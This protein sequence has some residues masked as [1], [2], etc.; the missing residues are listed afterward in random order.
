MC[1]NAA[2]VSYQYYLRGEHHWS[3]YYLMVWTL[4]MSVIWVS[5]LRPHARSIL[6]P[7][8][9]C[10]QAWRGGIPLNGQSQPGQAY[11]TLRHAPSSIHIGNSLRIWGRY[12]GSLVLEHLIQRPAIWGPQFPLFYLPWNLA[13][14]L[15]CISDA[16]LYCSQSLNLLFNAAS[17]IIDGGKCWTGGRSPTCKTRSASIIYMEIKATFI[18][19]LGRQRS[20]GFV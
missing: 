14:S 8:A 9:T 13:D 6:S 5:V 16:H 18:P 11:G 1:L 2:V 19:P 4:A 12:P 3:L 15:C 20:S 7:V 10:I 17:L